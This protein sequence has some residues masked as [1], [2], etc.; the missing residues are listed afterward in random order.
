M[1]KWDQILEEDVDIDELSEKCLNCKGLTRNINEEIGNNGFYSMTSFTY[2]DKYVF[3]STPGD[4]FNKKRIVLLEDFNED[5]DAKYYLAESL[6][7][8]GRSEQAI[9]LLKYIQIQCESIEVLILLGKAYISLGDYNNSE[10]CFRNAL[11]Y[12]F[13]NAL[14]YRQLGDVCQ[15]KGD[16]ISSIH[17]YQQSLDNFGLAVSYSKIENYG[18]VIEYSNHYLEQEYDWESLKIIVTEQRE[19]KVNYM[20]IDYDIFAFSTLYQLMSISYLELNNLDLALQ[21]IDRAVELNNKDVSF[22]KIQGIIIGRKHGQGEIV[23]YE[24]D[25]KMLKAYAELRASSITTLKS[26][27]PDEQVILYTGNQ[28]DN[29]KNFLVKQIFSSLRSILPLTS[30]ITPS[31]E[32]AADEDKYTDLFRA[33]MKWL[34]EVFGWTTHTQDRGGFTRDIFG[35]RGGIGERDIVIKSHEDK[36][37]MIGEALILKG[38]DTTVIQ[39]HTEKPFGYDIQSA[40]FQIIII[41]GFSKTPDNLWGKYKKLVL[42][43]T[44]GF[45][46]V[47][48][49]EK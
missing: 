2:K 24:E 36:D 17:Y 45:F 26:F 28:D 21:Y 31:L 9:E 49:L 42:S 1:D 23:K 32:Q 25:I 30:H 41:W 20:N 8:I 3:S 4:L 22:A 11:K 10:L 7:G 27:S 29:V 12:D 38:L 34:N 14:I 44:K 13:N 37:L 47:T 16:Y 33:N 35:V 48:K 46:S 15:Y 6:Y 18:K 39:T 43:R 5:L 40:N 19:G